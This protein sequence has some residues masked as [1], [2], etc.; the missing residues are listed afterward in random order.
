[1]GA[2]T[3]IVEGKREKIND[4]DLCRVNLLGGLGTDEAE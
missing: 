3:E 1:M 2:A 4:A